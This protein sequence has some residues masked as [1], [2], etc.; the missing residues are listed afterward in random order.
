M[1][2]YVATYTKISLEL[3]Y[4]SNRNNQSLILLLSEGEYYSE[5]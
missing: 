4:S 5:I 3:H 1:P 2:K